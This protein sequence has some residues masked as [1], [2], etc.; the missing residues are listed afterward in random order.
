MNQTYRL[1]E[2]V[3]A[4]NPDA[5]TTCGSG[6]FVYIPEGAILAVQDRSPRPGMLE[7]L[8]NDGRRYV[9]FSEDLE[10]RGTAI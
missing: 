2:Q 4:I 1:D 8:C 3:P 9:L 10:N 7:V 5:P 6:L